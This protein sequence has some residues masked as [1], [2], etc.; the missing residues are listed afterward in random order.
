M[1]RGASREDVSR[2]DGGGD[3]IRRLGLLHVDPHRARPGTLRGDR[4]RLRSTETRAWTEAASPTMRGRRDDEMRGRIT[5]EGESNLS[6]MLEM[7]S[8][9]ASMSKREDE[10]VGEE[11]KGM[12]QSSQRASTSAGTHARCS[13]HCSSDLE[14]GRRCRGPSMHEV[15]PLEFRLG[16]PPG[17]A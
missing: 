4:A 16:H 9:I 8:L 17:R 14:P 3:G 12:E 5:S 13:R 11:R 10:M 1:M 6:W 15:F 2:C 7:V